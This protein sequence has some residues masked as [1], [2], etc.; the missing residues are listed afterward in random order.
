MC[1]NQGRWILDVRS[2]ATGAQSVHRRD[3]RSLRLRQDERA[4]GEDGLADQHAPCRSIHCHNRAD[5]EF[6]VREMTLTMNYYLPS[7]RRRSWMK[8]RGWSVLWTFIS[9]RRMEIGLRCVRWNKT[10]LRQQ[11]S[12]A[13]YNM[14][15]YSPNIYFSLQV[16]LPFKPYLYIATKKVRQHL[17]FASHAMSTCSN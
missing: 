15:I 1:L 3:G 10:S 8:T 16:A 5:W 11:A 13:L 9:F 2:Q 17:S 4:G 6:L 7:Y 14:Q 12:Y